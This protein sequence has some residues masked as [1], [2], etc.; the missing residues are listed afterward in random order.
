MKFS[1][2]TLYIEKYRLIEMLKIA[3]R[4]Q[5]TI[6]S[7]IENKYQQQLDSINL[8]I[9][10]LGTCELIDELR[11]FPALDCKKTKCC[12]IGPITN[13]NY[14]PGCGKEIKR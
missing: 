2:E 13:E 1:I 7:N 10:K 3:D 8:A 9:D 6:M 11:D 12:D 5:D 14:C 4:N